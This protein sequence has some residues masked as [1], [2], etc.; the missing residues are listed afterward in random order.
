MRSHA[1]S[2]KLIL[3]RAMLVDVFRYCTYVGAKKLQLLKQ[4]LNTHLKHCC[5]IV[6]S[7]LSQ[8]N[9]ELE[10]ILDFCSSV[11]FPFLITLSYPS[12]SLIIVSLLLYGFFSNG[13]KKKKKVGKVTKT[14]TFDHQR[15]ISLSLNQSSKISIHPSL[16]LKREK[17]EE[18][19]VYAAEECRKLGSW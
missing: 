6:S 12:A 18:S 5:K 14:L 10:N 2:I 3:I 13:C 15:A 11:D 8:P 7:I 16:P 1:S 17:Q 19:E 9:L 4:I